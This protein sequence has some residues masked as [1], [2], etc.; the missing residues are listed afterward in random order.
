MGE[1]KRRKQLGL[2]PTVFPFEVELSAEGKITLLKAPDD[3]K[4]RDTLIRDLEKTQLTGAAWE[5]EYRT[6][7]V[8]AGREPGILRSVQDVQAIPV[9]TLRRISGD[10]VLGKPLAEVHGV[11]IP[12]DGGVIRLREQQHSFDGQK[13]DSFPAI[14][15]P[16]KIM[17]KLRLHP[18]FDLEGESL[19]QFRVEQYAEGRM[20]IEPDPPEG[21][22]EFLE[23]VGREWHGETPAKWLEIHQDLTDSDGP[24]PKMK[25]SYFELRRTA[26]LQNPARMVFAT[27]NNVEI[28]P[29]EGGTFSLDGET[30]LSYDDPDA[31]GQEDDFISAFGDMLNMET[32]QV[33]VYADGQVDW[34]EDEI[35]AEQAERVRAELREATGAG[36]PEKWADWT[37]KM[38]LDT[39]NAETEQEGETMPI[40]V[41]V[42]VDLPKDAIEDPDPLGQTFIE[43]E[44]T[45]DGENW[46][47][48]YD[49]E[50]PQ[51]LL[52]AIANLKPQE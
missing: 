32:V 20:D 23:E 18:A 31:E 52:L 1:A 37:R 50:V 11:A 6:A 51:E 29:L 14:R 16:E 33:T 48:L 40:P 28:Y 47:D 8:F 38:L 17:N 5:S 35:A 42:R 25:R 43:S 22:L 27:R 39:F 12:F 46:R 49:E 7:L 9:P 34:D 10:L 45:F 4:L 21:M 30:W 19:G 13:W 2:M 26:P 44:V 24:A 41:A 36:T 15:D 3:Q